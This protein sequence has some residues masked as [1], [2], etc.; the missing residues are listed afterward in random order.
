M[1][2]ESLNKQSCDTICHVGYALNA[3]KLRRSGQS[4]AEGQQGKWFGGGLADIVCGSSQHVEGVV[5]H[6]WN[7]ETP[8]AQQPEYHIIIHKL[9]EDILMD[10]DGRKLKELKDYLKRYPKTVII[11]PIEAVQIVL[12]RSHTCERLQNV[13]NIKKSNFPYHCP[14]AIPK[15]IVWSGESMA[16]DD[17]QRQ[18]VAADLVLPV[19][20]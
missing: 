12:S 19:S 18:L 3:K 11:D 20:L 10:Q 4:V 9:T 16:V 15:F 17:I 2:D 5:F 7:H 6:P 8:L 13:I 14:F 1:T